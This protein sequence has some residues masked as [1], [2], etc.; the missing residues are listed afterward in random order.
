MEI[1]L[2]FEERISPI[3]GK[4]MSQSKPKGFTVIATLSLLM[5]LLGLLGILLINASSL[6]QHV[7]N[8]VEMTVFFNTD[9][10]NNS[11]KEL[12]DSILN[13]PFA[14]EGTFVSSDEAVFNFKNE[15][16]QDFVDILGNN[17]LPA[18]LEL[19]LK[20]EYTDEGS[21][22]RIERNLSRH[23]DILEVSYP[24]NVFQQIDKN[25]R[26]IMF[27]L[28]ILS[29][30]MVL[31]SAVLMANTIRILIYSDRFIIKNQQLI[32]ATEK[33]IL[34]PYKRKAIVW[35]F[36]SFGIGVLL[37]ALLLWLIFS[38]LDFSVDLNMSAI[39]EHFIQNWYQYFLMLF[40][41]LAGGAAVIYSTTYYATKKYLR[42]HAD[43]LYT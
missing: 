41:L 21:L 26:I 36:I 10:Q 8:N 16:G 35:T 38:W 4:I 17:P 27:W 28:M 24:Q 11:A 34:R 3:F 18:S 25:R 20:K 31:I 42:T 14:K 7:K 13:L 9:L 37:L 39:G 33:F 32:G 15:I 23:R 6:N 2:I 29:L 22:M 40:L 19:A 5:F 30:V 12:C 43:N 1:F